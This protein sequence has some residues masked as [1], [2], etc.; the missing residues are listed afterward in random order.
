MVQ[1]RLV[2]QGPLLVQVGRVV[3]C[4]PHGSRKGPTSRK[5]RG[6]EEKEKEV[7]PGGEPRHTGTRSI[8]GMA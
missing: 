1:D 4:V 2:F 8:R 5:E 6:M 3:S 7:G